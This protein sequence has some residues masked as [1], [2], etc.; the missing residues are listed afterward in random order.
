M[1]CSKETQGTPFSGPNEEKYCYLKP[2][3]HNLKK[4]SFFGINVGRVSNLART[5]V[6]ARVTKSLD[7]RYR[8]VHVTKSCTDGSRFI[9]TLV[10]RNWSSSKVCNQD[11]YRWATIYR[12]MFNSKL[13]F[14]R[15]LFKT[16]SFFLLCFSFLHAY[17]ISLRKLEFL[18][19]VLFVRIKREPP[20]CAGIGSY[21]ST[22][23]ANQNAIHLAVI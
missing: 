1:L 20:V 10:L 17:L 12:N 11:P 7:V 6:R 3:V 21:L 8:L 13:R 16:T 15:I 2:H 23:A 5:T 9:R 22:F 19:S 4:R 14:I 18:R